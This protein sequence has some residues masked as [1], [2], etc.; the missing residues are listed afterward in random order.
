MFE[1]CIVAA[2]IACAIAGMPA[3][4]QTT[5]ERGASRGALLYTTHCIACHNTQMHWRDARVVK[6]WPGLKAEVRR[7]QAGA[8][9]AWSDEDIAEVTRHLN[10]LYYGFVEPQ[11]RA[12]APGGPQGASQPALLRLKGVRAR[13]ELQAQPVDLVAREP[14][15]DRG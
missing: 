9:L 12:R 15:S 10:A 8:R 6:D 13:G 3:H 5:P 14:S 4:A 11:A 1:R 2:S 7:W